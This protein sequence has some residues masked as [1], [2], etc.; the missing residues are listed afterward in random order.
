LF[1]I[2]HPIYLTKD[3]PSHKIEDYCLFKTIPGLGQ[4]YSQVAMK[5]FSPEESDQVFDPVF[6]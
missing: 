2:T 3:N 4:R 6:F 5:T 1:S